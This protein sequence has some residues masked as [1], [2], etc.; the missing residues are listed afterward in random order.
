MSKKSPVVRPLT[1]A[2]YLHAPVPVDQR[3]S[4]WAVFAVFLGFIVVAG[5]MS[6]GGGLASQLTRSE[7]IFAVLL[8]NAIA[9]GFAGFAA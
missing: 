4:A 8:G 6:V 2:D 1:D 5:Q 7:L 3:R 9:G